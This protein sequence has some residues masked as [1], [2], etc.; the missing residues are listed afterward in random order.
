MTMHH[1]QCNFKVMASKSDILNNLR[2]YTSDQIAE[3]IN[4]G[5]VTIYELS[6]SGNLTPLMRRRIE[7]K[8]ATKTSEVAQTTSDVTQITQDVAQTLDEVIPSVDTSETDYEEDVVI[9]EAS[10]MDIPSEIS[11]QQVS[12]ITAT[13][14]P[15]LEAGK[16]DSMTVNTE[17]V[18][19]NK[20]MFK[21]PFSFNG[22]I[23]RL[24][25]GISF[26][27]FS[28]WYVVIDVMSKSSDP[29][30][31]ASI[32]ILISFIPMIWFLWAQNAKR[33]H[34]RGNSGWYQ[35]I[36]FYFFVLLFG[37]GDEGE[38]EYGDNPK[39]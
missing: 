29:S 32:F 33:C 39:E 31:A 9:P 17:D 8:L 12:A 26:I 15:T 25:Y 13:A 35:L 37:D 22:R 19:S 23:R 2:E 16:K 4:A 21:R 3:A 28:I 7:E 20:G 36:P 1:L 5:I 38:N 30:P 18:I 14:S 6:K 27:I 11:I 34:D 24:E 10:E